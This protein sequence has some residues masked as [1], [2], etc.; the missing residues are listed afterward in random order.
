LSFAPHTGGVESLIVPGGRNQVI[1]YPS[2][3]K[4]KVKES[5]AEQRAQALVARVQSGLRAK[6]LSTAPIFYML[7]GLI[8]RC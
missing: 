6:G 8:G 7:T 1:E 4:E 5:P 2:D 3:T